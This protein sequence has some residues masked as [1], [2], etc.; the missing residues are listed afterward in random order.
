MLCMR[1]CGRRRSQGKEAG[2]SFVVMWRHSCSVVDNDDD[3]VDDD[4]DW[5]PVLHCIYMRS[6]PKVVSSISVRQ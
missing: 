4:D 6:I 5:Y 3:V 1:V 2:V